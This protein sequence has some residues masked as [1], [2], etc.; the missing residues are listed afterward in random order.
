M[1]PDAVECLQVAAEAVQLCCVCFLAF[2]ALAVPAA[3][4]CCG[5]PGKLFVG[6]VSTSE[7]H[8]PGDSALRAVA[9]AESPR[10]AEAASLMIL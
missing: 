2:T 4:N 7:G 3:G 1:E 5:I 6:E 8:R 9:E 10:A